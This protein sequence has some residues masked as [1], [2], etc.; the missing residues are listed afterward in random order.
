MDT[1]QSWMKALRPLALSPEGKKQ[2]PFIY[3][4]PIYAVDDDRK[5]VLNAEQEKLIQEPVS[6]PFHSLYM[7]SIFKALWFDTINPW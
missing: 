5:P 4:P 2:P 3:H 1:K 7:V 6:D